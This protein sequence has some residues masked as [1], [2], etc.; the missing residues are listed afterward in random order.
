MNKPIQPQRDFIAIDVEYANSEQ[1]ICQVGIAEVRNLEV[2]R[3]LSWLIQPPGNIYEEGFIRTHHITPDMT[4]RLG[5]FDVAWQEIQPVL[6]NYTQFWAHNAAST[7]LP[8]LTKNLKACGYAYEWLDIHDSRDLYQRPDLPYNSGNTLQMCCM[9]LGIDFDDQQYH[10][11]EYDALKCAEIVVAAARGQQPD[12]S[13]VARNTEELRKQQQ[14]KLILKPGMFAGHQKL[15]DEQKK[16]GL[17]GDKFDLFAELASTY[18][19]AQPQ[20]VDVFDKGDQMQKDGADLVDFARVDTSEGNPLRG[21][22]VAITGAFHIS[23]KEIERALAAM[24]ATTDGMTKNTDVLLVG[25]RNVGLPKL[26]KY[27]KQT[28]KRPVALVVGD[29]DLDVF[30]YGDGSK[31]FGE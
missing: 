2:V 25:N 12:W 14:A 19:G 27:E 4:A 29:A 18:A 9:A 17:V 24:G 7:E 21:K 26:A 3:T 6:L 1:D 16:A 15:Q 5:G 8:V 22:V 13:G 11:A 28:A 31:F 23:R 30:L 10:G 20:V